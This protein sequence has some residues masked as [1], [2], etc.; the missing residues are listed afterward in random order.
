MA[1]TFQILGAYRLDL[2]SGKFTKIEGRYW[3]FK[4]QEFTSFR[5]GGIKVQLAP[6]Y[7]EHYSCKEDEPSAYREPFID[8]QHFLI[9]YTVD[10][11]QIRTVKSQPRN[12]HES[13]RI[14]RMET[15]P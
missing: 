14:L 11:K 7:S 9:M 5:E 12:N 8:K 10:V 2:E 1:A 6:C 13:P 4:G 15:L 3:R